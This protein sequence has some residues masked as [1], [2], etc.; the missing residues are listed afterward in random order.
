MPYNARP[1]SQGFQCKAS[2]TGLIVQGLYHMAYN[3]RAIFVL[4]SGSWLSYLTDLISLR[5]VG[6]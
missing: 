1:I 4:Y 6:D 2:I 5:L 3:A